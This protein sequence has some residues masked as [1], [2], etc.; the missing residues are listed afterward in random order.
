VG[1]EGSAVGFAARYGTEGPLSRNRVPVFSTAN[2]DRSPALFEWTDPAART[3]A[4]SILYD[5]QTKTVGA[6]SYP[7]IAAAVAPVSA[8]LTMPAEFPESP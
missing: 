3:Q 8:K 4:I 2:N 1:L 7:A 6:T 5:T